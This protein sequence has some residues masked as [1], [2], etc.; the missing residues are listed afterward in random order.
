MHDPVRMPRRRPAGLFI[1][2]AL[3]LLGACAHTPPPAPSPAPAL[4]RIDGSTP[5]AFQ[6]SWDRMVQSLSPQGQA[7]LSVA[8]LT[9]ALG[10][11]KSANAVPESVAA[12]IGP[13]TIRTQVAGMTFEQILELARQQPVTVGV[14]TRP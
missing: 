5:E 7:A 13:Q 1:A 11:Y 6:A 10:Q 12:N 3:T 14:S 8:M 4:M 9:I 2:M